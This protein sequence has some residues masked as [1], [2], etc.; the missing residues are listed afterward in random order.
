MEELDQILADM[1]RV[2]DDLGALADD[3]FDERLR[4]L[5]EQKRLRV[6]AAEVRAAAP[7]NRA[8]LEA[9]LAGLLDRWDGIQDQRIDVVMQSGGGS[10]GGDAFSGAH[11]VRMNQE[12][13]QALGREQIELRIAEIRRLLEP[14]DGQRI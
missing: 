13:D 9:E 11:A 3:A 6:R 7:I 8:A 2:M 4:L 14:P 1:G 10:Q 5:Q 12:I